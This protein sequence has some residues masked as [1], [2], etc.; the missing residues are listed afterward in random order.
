MLNY[1]RLCSYSE[2]EKWLAIS[3]LEVKYFSNGTCDAAASL[4]IFRLK[5][6]TDKKA[7]L[8]AS[9]LGWWEERTP[10][11]EGCLWPLPSANPGSLSIVW[12]RTSR[13]K[14]P[15]SHAFLS[16][17]PSYF[18]E[19]GISLSPQ[20]RDSASLAAGWATGNLLSLLPCYWD[21][22]QGLLHLVLCVCFLLVRGI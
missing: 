8:G 5:R 20:L 3:A 7:W 6:G 2:T 4:H 17:S 9:M 18:E 11:S 13:G 15:I 16:H 19:K 14:Q 10:E 12:E 22:K 21:Y 1:R